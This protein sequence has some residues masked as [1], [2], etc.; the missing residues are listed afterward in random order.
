MVR[1]RGAGSAGARAQG[2]GA[3]QCDEKRRGPCADRTR[4]RR[5]PSTPGALPGSWRFLLF[6]R[7]GRERRG[8]STPSSPPRAVT[9]FLLPAS[10][11]GRGESRGP[12]L[13]PPRGHQPHPAPQPRGSA[14]SVLPKEV[15]DSALASCGN[16]DSPSRGVASSPPRQ[17]P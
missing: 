6:K 14:C 11:S 3:P 1:E 12:F 13:V 8:D 7:G 16:S 10:A 5:G 9:I 15:P 4:R 17:H 2:G